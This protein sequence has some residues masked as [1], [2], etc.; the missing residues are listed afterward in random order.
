LSIEQILNHF[1]KIQLGDIAPKELVQMDKPD[2]ELVLT[3][4]LPDGTDINKSV[5]EVMKWQQ[6]NLDIMKK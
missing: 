2:V 6:T 1:N 5:E 4:T 3:L